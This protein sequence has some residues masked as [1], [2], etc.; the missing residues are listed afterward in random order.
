[1]KKVV[2]IGPESTGKSTLS[3]RLATHF[4]TVWTPEFAREYIDQLQR[5]Y[6]QHDLLKIA[7]GQ[8]L[9]E[10]EQKKKAKDLLICDTDLY[11]I[12][13]W[14]E[15]KY[16]DC[17]AQI[18]DQIA[19]QQC[20]LYLLTYIDLPW[21]EDPQREYPDPEMRQYFY[22]IYKDIVTQSGAP[23]VEIRGDYVR[24]EALAVA[25]VQQLLA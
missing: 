21:E 20:D 1:M 25:A 4:H 22:N 12:K 24:R 13:V 7:T 10:E 3:E 14:S 8:L 17:D 16:G 19:R 5:P 11:V 15:H 2:V 9:L 23:F 6:E 18:L